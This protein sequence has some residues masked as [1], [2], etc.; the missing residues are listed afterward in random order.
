MVSFRK[1]FFVVALLAMVAGLASASTPAAISC[2]SPIAPTTI[3]RSEGITELIDTITVATTCTI[4]PAIG[5]ADPAPTVAPFT[6]QLFTTSAVPVTSFPGNDSTISE[7]TLTISQPLPLPAFATNNI[8]IHGTVSGNAITFVGA[9]TTALVLPITGG[10]FSIT[11]SGLRVDASKIASGTA[12]GVNI[13]ALSNNAVLASSAIFGAAPS[14]PL[15]QIPN[16][17]VALTSL[18]VASDITVA[19]TYD[20]GSNKIPLQPCTIDTGFDI[21]ADEGDNATH[22][23][24]KLVFTGITSN[25][26]QQTVWDSYTGN[27][28]AATATNPGALVTRLTFSIT[29]VPAGVTLYTPTS[30]VLDAGTAVLLVGYDPATL[31]G[32]YAFS[33][34]GGTAK[35]QALTPN[36]SGT[37]TAVYQLSGFTGGTNVKVPIFV[38]AS[39]KNPV[40]PAGNVAVSGGYAP[41]ATFASIPRFVA[42]GVVGTD[43]VS[44][45]NCTSTLLF[46]YVVS[47][48]G[49]DTGIAITNSG[50]KATDP[51]K[52]Q[53]GNCKF[54]FYGGGTPAPTFSFPAAI[55]PGSSSAFD[56]VGSLPGVAITAGYAVAVCDFSGVTGYAFVVSGSG[57]SEA[58]AS[59]LPILIHGGTAK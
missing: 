37:V 14:S 25:A 48:G 53:S 2:L 24:V 12:M 41:L 26:F 39:I 7:P 43:S 22:K 42:G 27:S 34:T 59:Y 32:G 56:I 40:A 16:V 30:P 13:L 3:L 8:P 52:G 6:I 29:N 18:G 11:I 1:V 17:A 38:Y 50:P 57:A 47:G 33:A 15:L 20:A 23:F 49:Y 45:S 5:L 36:A 21:T 58:T 54:T 35:Y 4:T 55:A 46:P 31:A 51:T 10:T 19:P 9:D 44:Y 28:P